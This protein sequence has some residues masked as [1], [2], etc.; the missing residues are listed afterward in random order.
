MNLINH[1]PKHIHWFFHPTLT[2]NKQHWS[3]LA[4]FQVR[5]G[6][7]THSE[8][9]TIPAETCCS[10]FCWC[11]LD[12]RDLGDV[13]PHLHAA[14]LWIKKKKGFTINPACAAVD[15]KTFLWVWI[16]VLGL[17][18]SPCSQTYLGDEFYFLPNTSRGGCAQVRRSMW[19]CQPQMCFYAATPWYERMHWQNHNDI[20]WHAA[21]IWTCVVTFKHGELVLCPH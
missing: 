6:D 15:C 20:Q 18:P 16:S 17:V 12:L 7:T 8:W 9:P 4:R 2:Q 5:T 1:T 21:C 11:L 10:C 19:L 14:A 13:V 3:Y